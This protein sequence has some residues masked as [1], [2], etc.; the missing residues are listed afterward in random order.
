M[1]TNLVYT[2]EDGT[3]AVDIRKWID[4]NESAE[5]ADSRRGLL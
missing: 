3:G 1:S 5:D 4:Q 2:I